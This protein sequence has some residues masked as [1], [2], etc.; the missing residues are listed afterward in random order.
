MTNATGKSFNPASGCTNFCETERMCEC[1]GLYDTQLETIKPCDVHQVWDNEQEYTWVC[2]SPDP[3]GQVT[4]LGCALDTINCVICTGSTEL[5]C[6]GAQNAERRRVLSAE[7]KARGSKYWTNLPGGEKEA[8]E[9]LA[10]QRLSCQLCKRN[11]VDSRI[12]SADQHLRECSWCVL[13]D[14]RC[15]TCTSENLIDTHSLKLRKTSEAAGSTAANTT[16][17][18]CDTSACKISRAPLGAQADTNTSKRNVPIKKPLSP[19]LECTEEDPN[20]FHKLCITSTPQ[21]NDSDQPSDSENVKSA[22]DAFWQKNNA[23]DFGF[24]TISLPYRTYLF[25]EDCET[26][27]YVRIPTDPQI[28]LTCCWCVMLNKTCLDCMSSTEFTQVELI[29]IGKPKCNMLPIKYKCL[30]QSACS[31]TAPKKNPRNSAC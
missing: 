29:P 30:A 27:G 10:R 26:N 15:K 6:L 18:C 16:W 23:S 25:C 13:L 3:S 22:F 31:K 17:V 5:Q 28:H 19:I 12:T 14:E 1:R 21:G 24:S 7:E 9:D 8:L 11:G 4:N 2:Q 20:R